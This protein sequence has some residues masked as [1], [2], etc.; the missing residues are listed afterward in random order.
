MW[1]KYTHVEEKYIGQIHRIWNSIFL[2]CWCYN[3]LFSSIHQYAT[4]PAITSLK[5]QLLN[6]LVSTIAQLEKSI[7]NIFFSTCKRANF[8]KKGE[9]DEQMF[10]TQNPLINCGIRSSFTGSNLYMFLEHWCAQENT[11][12]NVCKKLVKK[13]ITYNK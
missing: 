8:I 7:S 2:K 3:I 13:N 1:V 10:I 4:L 6:C 9:R 5:N 11:C 12:E